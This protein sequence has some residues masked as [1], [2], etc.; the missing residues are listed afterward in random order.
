MGLSHLI[1][2]SMHLGALFDAHEVFG[3]AGVV[4]EPLPVVFWAVFFHNAVDL[5]P[6]QISLILQQSIL[7]YFHRDHA[8]VHVVLRR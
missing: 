6:A 1:K 2:V 8:R 4:D 3:D 7:E 5:M